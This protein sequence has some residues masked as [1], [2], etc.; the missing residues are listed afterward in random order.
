MRTVQ[1]V[2]ANTSAEAAS[3]RSEI[4]PAARNIIGTI[5]SGSATIV[6]AI[7][8]LKESNAAMIKGQAVAG[9]AM[10]TEDLYGKASQP[11]GLC[12]ANSLGAGL[13]LS[14]QAAVQVRGAMRQKQLAYSNKPDA[15]PV[16]YLNRVLDEEH[17]D[18][19]EGGFPVSPSGNAH[20]GTG[21]PG[22]RIHQDT[23]HI[24][25]LLSLLR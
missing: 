13:Q 18:A 1:T 17:P 24:S 15:K 4:L 16:E 7:I 2:N 20:G 6:R 25:G 8:S 22:A 5:K 10:K 21:C 19:A 14:A 23:G 9:E 3:I 11:A 12:G